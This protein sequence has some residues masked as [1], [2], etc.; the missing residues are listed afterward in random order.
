MAEK[1][2]ADVGM[3]IR[4]LRQYDA[5]ID[6]MPPQVDFDLWRFGSEFGFVRRATAVPSWTVVD[7]RLIRLNPPDDMGDL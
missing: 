3:S 5:V 2:T 1:P 4:L 6:T 7:N